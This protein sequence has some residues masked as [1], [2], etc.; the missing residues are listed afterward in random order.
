M[1]M[2]RSVMHWRSSPVTIGNGTRLKIV[3]VSTAWS[4][5]G[6]TT[7]TADHNINEEKLSNYSYCLVMFHRCYRWHFVKILRDK[8]RRR[9][10]HRFTAHGSQSSK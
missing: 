10:G 6:V 4:S 2:Q 5:S 1:L 8:E 9:I 7:S 3:H